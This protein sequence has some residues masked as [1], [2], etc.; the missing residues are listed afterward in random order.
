MCWCYD[1]LLCDVP[2]SCDTVV[3]IS[4]SVWDYVWAQYE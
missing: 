1:L 2:D 4:Y 3:L